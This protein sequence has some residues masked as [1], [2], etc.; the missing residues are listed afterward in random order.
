LHCTLEDD[1]LRAGDLEEWTDFT[2]FEQA[3]QR[4]GP[5]I[6]G[7]DFPFGQARL[8]IQTIDWPRDWRTTC[9]MHI[10]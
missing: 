1:V 5:W 9:A 2:A 4:P 8:F 6:A 7:I 10:L 3:L